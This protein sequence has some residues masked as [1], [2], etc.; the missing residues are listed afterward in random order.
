MGTVGPLAEGTRETGRAISS[1]VGWDTHSFPVRDALD[2]L[3]ASFAYRDA[4]WRE[5]RHDLPS[6]PIV[7]PSCRPEAI[8][9]SRERWRVCSNCCSDSFNDWRT[10]P[11]SAFLRTFLMAVPRSSSLRVRR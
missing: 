7:I 1:G 6:S 9:A 5:I 11:T 8:I 4:S 3:R 10:S 2:S